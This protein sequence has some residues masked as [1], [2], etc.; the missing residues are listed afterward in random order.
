MAVVGFGSAVFQ[1]GNESLSDGGGEREGS[2]VT[3]LALW[4]GQ[5]LPLPVD[6]IEGQS[7]DFPA[8][9][10]IDDKQ[11]EDGVVPPARARATVHPRQDLVHLVPGDRAGQARQPVHLRPA[12]RSGKVACEHAFPVREAQEHSQHPG[13]VPDS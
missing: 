7:R 10:P 1:V 8:P 6:V 11:E 5:P 3:S 9:Q 12:D 4:D 2:R 13:A